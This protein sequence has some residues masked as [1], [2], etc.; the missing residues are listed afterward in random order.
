M[1]RTARNA[2]ARGVALTAAVLLVTTGAT[3]CTGDGDGERRPDASAAAPTGPGAGSDLPGSLTGQKPDWKRCP[4]PTPIQGA[5][6]GRPAPLPDGTAWECAT[7]KAPLD[8]TEPDGET[9]DLALI[10][11]RAKPKGGEKRIGSLVFNFGGPGGS[12]VSSL[13]SFAAQ[14]YRT[15]HERYDLVSFDPRGVGES[16][17]VQCLSDEELDTWFATDSTPDDPGEEKE[18]LAGGRKA[19]DGCEESSGELLPHVGTAAAARDMDLMRQV[20]GDD[21]LHYFGVSYGTELGGVYA[22]LFPER[23]GRAVFDAVVDPTADTAEGALGQAKGFQ[24]ALDNF[25]ADCAKQEDCPTG[26]ST[27]EG[28]KKIA[29]LVKR[30]DG[31]SLPAQGDRRLTQS[32]VV[33]GIAAA[34]YSR[35]AWGVLKQ[36]LQEVELLKTGNVLLALSDSLTGRD[37]KGRYSNIQSANTAVNC[38]DSKDRY[39]ADQV[40]KRLPSFREA[41]PVFGDFLAWSMLQCTGWPVEGASKTVDVEAEGSEPILVVGNTGDPATPYEGAKR[42]ADGL[43]DDVGVEL[44]YKGEG[45]GAYGNSRCVTEAVNGYLLEGEV[46]RDGKVCS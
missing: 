21:R 8:Y 34:L 12:G 4:A 29:A 25:L 2:T 3:S 30:L 37:E 23:V 24:L 14:E 42:M 45:H 46:P 35:E 20:L 16:E 26:K 18:F 33:N 7:L 17:G 6:G 36:G 28:R 39:T 38:A 43:G 44:T 32:H 19:A 22:N 31:T 5:T 41:S 11:A 40:Q 9:I 15:L 1:R 13:P 27:V 10:R